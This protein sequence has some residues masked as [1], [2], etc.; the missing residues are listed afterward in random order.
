[1]IDVSMRFQGDVSPDAILTLY[2]LEDHGRVQQTVDRAVIDY[3]NPYWAYD[4]GT[5]A[6]SAY[7]ASDIG[8]GIIVY[9]ESYAWE[10]YYGV[11]ADGS[12]FNYHLDKHPQAGAYPFDRMV[13]DH[14][15]DI[16]EEATRSA[17]GE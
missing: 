17:R 15:D 12:T 14:F 8:S 2:G 5:L 4:T 3:M 7:S 13:A 9:D 6:N 16:L 11:R 1:M 10:M